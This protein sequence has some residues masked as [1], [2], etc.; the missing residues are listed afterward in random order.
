MV[1][2]DDEYRLG[3]GSWSSGEGEGIGSRV[4]DR[5]EEEEEAAD[6]DDFEA[7]VDFLHLLSLP[8]LISSMRR[9]NP[10]FSAADLPCSRH[11]FCLER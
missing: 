7:A 8:V 2:F 10:F 9:F 3:F 5:D 1:W 4:V 6:A 11:S